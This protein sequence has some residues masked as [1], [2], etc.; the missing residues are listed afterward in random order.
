MV[1]VHRLEREVQKLNPEELAAFREWFQEYDSDA[2][3]RRIEEDI[4]AGRFDKLAE[5][6][7]EA[8]KS[9]RTTKL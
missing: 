8:H 7:V 3:D 4:R 1:K 5:G 2:W 6:A 9:G